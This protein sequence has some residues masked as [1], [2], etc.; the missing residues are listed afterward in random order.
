MGGV[1]SEKWSR[2]WV[3]APRRGRA[4]FMH[5]VHMISYKWMY[6]VPRRLFGKPNELVG[7]KKAGAWRCEQRVS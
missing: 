1:R 7:G 2:E 6:T 4:A 3:E 5:A